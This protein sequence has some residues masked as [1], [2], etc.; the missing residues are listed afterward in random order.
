MFGLL[1]E[2]VADG[3]GA[4]ID[5]DDLAVDDGADAVDV[6]LE[7]AGGDPGDFGANAAE[8]FGFAA[9]GDLVSEAGLFCGKMADARHS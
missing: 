1:D 7:F 5:A 8:V 2:A 6:G 4:D 3:F 9:V